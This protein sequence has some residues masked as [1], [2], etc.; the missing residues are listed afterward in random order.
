MDGVC[1]CPAL[2]PV[3]ACTPAIAI[4]SANLSMLN[5]ADCNAPDSFLHCCQ[6][7]QDFCAYL[8]RL[9]SSAMPQYR[10]WGPHQKQEQHGGVL[11]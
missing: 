11:E 7:L 8:R 3:V 6:F 4:A 5:N 2:A 1:I 9:S 10:A